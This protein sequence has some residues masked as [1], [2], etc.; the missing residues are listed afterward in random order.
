MKIHQTAIINKNAK[1]HESVQVGPYC[2]IN[3]H[4]QIGEGTVLGSHVV[5]DGYTKI[6]KGCKIHPFALIG[7]P[8]QD[9]KFKNERTFVRIGDNTTLR[10]YVTIN[11][12]TEKDSETIVGSNCFFMAYVHV[13]HNCTVG[14]GVIIA[15]CGTLAGHV[16]IGDKAIIGGLSGIHQFCRIGTLSL[17]GGCSKVVKDVPPYT[18][19]DG[20]PARV[21]TL[22]SIGLK[23]NNISDSSQEQ[24]KKVF[25]KIFKSKMS[26]TKAIEKI[27]KDTKLTK[28][29]SNLIDFIKSSERGIA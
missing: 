27:K 24:L 6:G 3:E 8:P 9:L 25:K 17:I 15:N 28:E 13:A 5:I 11:A 10:E 16:Q 18:I 4:V 12:A 14:D 20:H 2:V 7:G 21:R 26:V 19:V 23:R 22:N 29:T 1:L